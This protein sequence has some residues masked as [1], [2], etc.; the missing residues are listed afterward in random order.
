MRI[1][2]IF[3][4]LIFSFPAFTQDDGWELSEESNGIIV[5]TRKKQSEKFKEIKILTRYQ[6]TLNAIMAAFDDPE[7]HKEW[8]YKTPES[9]T[10]ERIDKNTLIYYV[11]SDF[12]FPIT[13][14]DLVMK[15]KW[16]QDP[17]TKV[18]FTESVGITGKVEETGST[19]RV[20]DFLSHYT[21]TPKKDGW[22]YIEFDAKM[23]P[24]GSLPAWLVNL[25]VTLG[26]I[27]TM[28]NLFEILDSGR[29]DNSQVEGVS[30]LVK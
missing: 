7:S 11:K 3:L 16:S 13:N 14:R 12:P 15:Y 9:Y 24:A 10:V 22:V 28:E 25:F 19:I 26:P 8:V 2:I 1:I 18:I 30:E 17:E 4:F 5:Y 21:L 23:D 20:K 29:Y 6:T 27:K